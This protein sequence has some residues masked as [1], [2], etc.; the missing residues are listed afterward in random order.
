MAKDIAAAVREICLSFPEAAERMS[1]GSP[2]FHVRG[3]AFASF[4][5]NHHGDGRVALWLPAPPGT[6][7][8][9]VE[10]EPDHFFVPP[11]VGTR[12]WLG[13]HL[14][15]GLDWKRVA[16]HVREAYLA[17][18]PKKLTLELPPA[19]VIKP[20]T[21]SIDPD[22]LDPL[23]SKRA[24]AVV[25]QLREFCLSLPEASEDTAFGWPVW[26]AGKKTFAGVHR[27]NRRLT[28]QFWVGHD[29]QAMLTFEKRY[30]IPAY[31][32]H[33]GWIELD[34]EDDV[35]FD[36]VRQL[37]LVSYKHFALKRMLDRLAMESEPPPAKPRSTTP[38]W[39]NQAASTNQARSAAS[40]L[41][42]SPKLGTYA[43]TKKSAGGRSASKPA[44]TKRSATK[45]SVAKQSASKR[46]G[47]SKST[48]AKSAPRANR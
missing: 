47:R 39:S 30:R 37:A 19:I 23:S 46:S 18:A 22:L 12:G 1:H 41:S 21:Q 25:P 33:N 27:Y 45:P 9:Y 20:P 31:M 17:V 35:D 26:R 11:Y 44:A 36:E 29:M 32:G 24:K 3:K 5:V 40:S 34:V 43:S 13:V 28:L 10:A 7:L 48:K 42:M 6:Q 8:H 38:T 4:V 14:N 2:D 16:H 15:K